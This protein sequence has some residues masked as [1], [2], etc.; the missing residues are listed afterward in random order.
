[1]DYGSEAEHLSEIYCDYDCEYDAD[2]IAEAEYQR[3]CSISTL[4]GLNQ[5]SISKK[6][7]DLYLI[8]Q[9]SRKD[10]TTLML[11]DR[12]KSK[13]YWWTHDLSIAYKGSKNELMK[14]VYKLQKNNARVISYLEY[15]NLQQH[16]NDNISNDF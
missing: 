2:S 8:I 1:M 13:K 9:D 5:V 12:R 6:K 15:L 14:V 4:L 16:G 10:D 3:R 11:V 7:K